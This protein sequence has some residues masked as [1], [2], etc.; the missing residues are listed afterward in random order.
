MKAI[1]ELFPNRTALDKEP[2]CSR[3]RGTLLG[4][5]LRTLRE[6]TGSGASFGAGSSW[7]RSEAAAAM[8]RSSR[9]S[10]LRIAAVVDVLSSCRNSV[11][12]MY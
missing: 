4:V 12:P 2:L 1:A 8:A 7:P 11:T 6:R 9:D 3:F 10:S 5:R